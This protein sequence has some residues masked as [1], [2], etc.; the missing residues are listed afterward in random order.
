M[1]L[2]FLRRHPLWS[3]AI[4]FVLLSIVIGP[5]MPGDAKPPARERATWDSNGVLIETPELEKL[6]SEYVSA[7]SKA[8]FDQSLLFAVQLIDERT[9][10]VSVTDAWRN[11]PETA[12]LAFAT[13]TW[14]AWA[15]VASPQDV[16]HAKINLVDKQQ[17]R[18]GGSSWFGGSQ[19]SV[20]D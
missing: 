6:Q 12:R 1:V 4:G 10:E 18:V 14:E 2:T 15:Q 13:T 17:H 7:L 16:D 20:N 8:D 11:Q 5:F 9:M 3:I 19:I